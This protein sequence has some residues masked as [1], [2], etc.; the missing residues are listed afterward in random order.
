MMKNWEKIYLWCCAGL[1]LLCFLFINPIRRLLCTVELANDVGVLFGILAV[2]FVNV[3]SDF[4]SG[5][6]IERFFFSVISFIAVCILFGG[7]FGMYEWIVNRI[8]FP[9]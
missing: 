9:A 6:G 1:Y 8:M 3:S 2:V 5:K 4:K 7:V